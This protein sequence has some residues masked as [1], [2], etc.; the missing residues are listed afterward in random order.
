MPVKTYL[1]THYETVL[2]YVEIF[3]V[4]VGRID[5][6]GEDIKIE[7]HFDVK[8]NSFETGKRKIITKR[9]IKQYYNMQII[10]G[11][12]CDTRSKKVQIFKYD[13]FLILHWLFFCIFRLKKVIFRNSVWARLYFHFDF[14][15]YHISVIHP[16]G[17]HSSWTTW[18]QCRSSDIRR[19][20]IVVCSPSISLYSL[21][22]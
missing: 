7:I 6:I 10:N 16:I 3:L 14:K 4:M 22:W 19:S 15:F 17:R 12:A 1:L 13:R 21:S 20:L 11:I 2:Y 18:I 9:G 8:K 5:F